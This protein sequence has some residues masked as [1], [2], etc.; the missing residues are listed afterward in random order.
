MYILLAGY[1][2]FMSE[3]ANEINRMARRGKLDFCGQEWTS[4]SKE[5]K[6]LIKHLMKV[7]PAKRLSAKDSLNSTW[8]KKREAKYCELPSTI[9]QLK[10]FNARRKLKK[11]ILVVMATRRFARSTLHSH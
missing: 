4:I 2:P 8:M 5:A 3:D 1:S 7:D 10:K 6:D 11:G 9:E